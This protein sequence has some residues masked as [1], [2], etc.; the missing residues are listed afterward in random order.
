MCTAKPDFRIR[1]PLFGRA[2]GLHCVDKR[3]DLLCVWEVAGESTA[4]TSMGSK[5]SVTTATRA[6]LSSL[7]GSQAFVDA[8]MISRCLLISFPHRGVFTRKVHPIPA[9]DSTSTV[10]SSQFRRT[11]RV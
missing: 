6:L 9:R 7:S 4:P 3:F 2:D 5:E 11:F 1:R 10:G 8:H